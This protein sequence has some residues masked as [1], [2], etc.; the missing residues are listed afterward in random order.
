MK[1]IKNFT[2]SR[3]NK[4]LDERL[5]PQGE[6]TDALN[7]RV[8]SSQDGQNAGAVR[9]S[10]G[11]DQLTQL[12]YNGSS[13]TA[14]ATAIGS[15]ADDTRETIYWWVHDPGNVDMLVS[16]NVNTTNVTYHLV[17]ENLLALDPSY[18]ITGVVMVE[19]LL[20]WTDNLNPPR[21]IN[22]N[23]SYPA[24]VASVD[25]ITADDINVIV[26]RPD[27]APTVEVAN[28]PDDENYMEDK[29]ISFA[30]R[31]RYVDNQYS[32]LSEFSSPAFTPREFNI[33]FT[34][35]ENAGMR[36]LFNACIVGFNTGGS[37][38]IGVD[39]CF[40]L[41]DSDIVYVV[42]KFSK[43]DRGWSD[44]YDATV[45]FSN[46]KVYTTLVSSEI[47]RR[48]DNVPKTARSLTS[49]GNR[50]VF[51]NYKEGY[52]IDTDLDYDLELVSEYVGGSSMD[53]FK[54]NGSTYLI[55]GSSETS[56]DSRFIFDLTGIELSEGS[57]LIMDI[58]ISHRKFTGSATYDAPTFPAPQN[59]FEYSYVFRL[60][61]TYVDRNDL[62][63]SS[64]FQD[65]IKAM[66]NSM[67]Q[68]FHESIGPKSNWTMVGNGI[69]TDN[70][71]FDVTAYLTSE[72]GVQVTAA[73]Y[74]DDG[75]PGTF[76]YEYF[77]FS[78]VSVSIQSERA[79]ESLHSN[80]DYEV[81]IEYMDDYGRSSTAL[82]DQDNTIFV[83][84]EN[85]D[86]RN[87]IRV[88]VNH[89]PPSWATRYRF[90]LKPS[91]IS[92]E[93]IYSLFYFQDT[94][95]S[96]WWFKLDGD[97][98]NK[99]SVGQ[100]LIVKSDSD[101]PLNRL[102]RAKVLNIKAQEDD[103][104]LPN[105]EDDEE[106]A[107]VYMNIRP[108]GFS[109]RRDP[110]DFI[111]YNQISSAGRYP[112]LSYFMDQ[113]DPD[114]PGTYVE[115]S[116]P[117]GSIVEFKI[118]DY[119]NDSALD[120]GCGSRRYEFNRTFTA[121]ASYDNMY[122]FIVGENINFSV[123]TN[124]PAIDGNDDIIASAEFLGLQ[125]GLSFSTEV[126]D[127]LDPPFYF[128]P[129]VPEENGVMKIVYRRGTFTDG[130]YGNASRSFL[131][132]RSGNK[133]CRR[134]GRQGNLHVTI[135]VTVAG[136]VAVFETEAIDANPDI[137]YESSV[138]YPITGGYHTGSSQD[139]DA[140]NPAIVDLNF[141]NCYSFGN[142]V[143][144]YKIGDAL[145]T[146]G[147]AIGSR[148]S[149]VSEQDFR[150]INRFADLT[151]SGVYNEET[152]VNKLNEF[153]LSL[154]NYKPLERVFGPINK[155]HGRRTDLLVLQEDKISYVL[156]GKNLLSDAAGG[157][158]ITSIPE[159]LGTQISRS[160]E[161]GISNN[162]E[163]F[164]FYGND[165][166]FPDAKRNAIINIKGSSYQ[167]DQVRV[168]SNTGM[169]DWFRDLFRGTLNKAKIGG[170][171]PDSGHYVFSAK[172]GSVDQSVVASIP[173]P[174]LNTFYN[175]S[176][177]ISFVIDFGNGYGNVDVSYG[178]DSG[179]ADIVVNYNGVDVIDTTISGGPAT[180]SFTK[181]QFDINTA[182]VTVTPTAATFRLLVECMDLTP[183]TVV[184][185][186]ANDEI[187][188]GQS[189][190]TEYYWSSG[191]YQSP[192]AKFFVSL[193]SSGESLFKSNTGN[194]SVGVFPHDGSTVTLRSVSKPGQLDFGSS[195]MKYLV[196]NTTYT[197]N[198]IKTVVALATNVTPVVTT[199]GESEVSFTYN[200][201]GDLTYL[202]L[203]WNYKGGASWDS[204]AIK[205]DSDETTFDET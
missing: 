155:L 141:F 44:D 114:N 41:S 82:V 117:A 93:T 110:T 140:S 7:A 46:K 129:E 20:F 162:P 182:T 113:E 105:T 125:E 136:A 104:I 179:S 96:S 144:S 6:Y 35:Y 174:Y 142:G 203:V 70:D 59:S 137:Y 180:L 138:S 175:T 74:E 187:L 168:I 26:K 156:A 16:Y 159:V 2:R 80:M 198:D 160:E 132:F 166:F 124:N 167:S 49:M 177:P 102:V 190:T 54:D 4:D 66:S 172:D 109:I 200:N 51:G 17:T 173:C 122:D 181:D 39:V 128:N 10:Y 185:I 90:L 21:Y 68:D 52:D 196:S 101:G 53:V 88:T 154:G 202:Y 119:R 91:K 73:K 133:W 67:T 3:M 199:S 112:Q 84:A 79:Y 176:T 43:E 14:N 148:V 92:Y 65:S 23:R 25:Q 29:F 151:Y 143:E 12:Q 195:E 183:I 61:R 8:T 32:A 188:A 157:G 131:T 40:K 55:E 62:L 89:T 139:Q 76:A 186:V 36:N 193:D 146:P 98:I 75:N 60:P 192:K 81:A 100:T 64:E 5:I 134:R 169:S 150:E 27:E 163:G 30:Y 194:E 178:F 118:L 11:T 86:L 108:G 56:I 197:D 189:A 50:L 184:N 77:Y 145:D 170:Y 164:A 126:E 1:L 97:N 171:D 161:Y 123:P 121:T 28:L 47:G 120:G 205:W 38:V 191:S 94:S 63:Y 201:P 147:L 103:F 158:N 95:T 85:S 45:L 72:I 135:N 87:Y 116:I 37:N 57:I 106:P 18:L 69:A 99:V 204:T 149:Q 9:N 71:R 115:Y 33:D 152:N 48:Y 127:D 22:I 153:N 111:T 83:P 34:N 31:W 107:G 78:A 58:T 24:P 13:L 15:Y 130:T 42:E 19:D 165:I